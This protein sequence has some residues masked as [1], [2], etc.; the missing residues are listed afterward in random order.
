[1]QP[2]FLLSLLQL[3]WAISC[4]S[5]NHCPKSAPCCS[6]YG[7]CGTGLLCLGGCDPRY[8]YNLLACMPMPRMDTFSYEFDDL[9]KVKKQ[10]DYLGNASAADWVYTGYVGIHDKALLL[11]MPNQS[12]GTVVSSTKY[13][14]YGKVAA[15]LKLSHDAGVITAFITFSD[16]QDEIDF[17]FL[18]YDL[19]QPQSNFYYHGV[20]N[21]T[22]ARN[23][24]S[25]DTF[26]NYH[27]YELDWAE[28]QLTWSIDGQVQRTLK[29]ADTWNLTQNKFMYPQTPSRIQF[30]LWPGGLSL[31]QLGTIEWAGGAINW[32]SQDIK[33][34]GYYYLYLKNILVSTYNLPSFVTGGNKSD[35]HAYLYNVLNPDEQNVF[36]TNKKTW[37]GNDDALGLDPDNDNEV[38]TT[39]VHTLGKNTT[40]VVKTSTKLPLAT[41]INANLPGEAKTSSTSAYTGGW[42]Q[43]LDETATQGQKAASGARRFHI[44]EAV[45]GL[46]GLAVL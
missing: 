1:M 42:V 45:W 18:G 30:S 2:I 4:N 17:E 34:Y 13:L 27:T 43:N 16:V 5:T 21:Y 33:Q 28:D 10:T 14:W 29:K 36:L 39:V 11:Q 26:A 31:N 22:N 12:T 23:L 41:T 9:S 46:V 6:Q 37:L 38:T 20:T 24:T 25:S 32:D 15:T 7:V 40:T 8:S 19:V 35:N 3:A 44:A